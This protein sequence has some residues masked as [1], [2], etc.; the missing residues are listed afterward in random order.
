M[1]EVGVT[2]ARGEVER[3]DHLRHADTGATRRTGTAVRHVCCGFFSVGV[4]ALDFRPALHF[5]ES[6][7]EHRGNHE[8]VRD[9][10]ALEHV[11]EA[12]SAGYFCHSGDFLSLCHP[13]RAAKDLLSW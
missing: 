11:R 6:P 12:L 10:V 8:H 4:D 2:Q 3:A 1:R 9:T 7:T 13:E 5:G